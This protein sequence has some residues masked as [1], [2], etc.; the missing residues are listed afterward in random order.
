MDFSTEVPQNIYKFAENAID[1]AGKVG[2]RKR[3]FATQEASNLATSRKAELERTQ[4]GETKRRGLIETGLKDRS[5]RQYG[6]GG[7]EDRRTDLMYGPESQPAREIGL[8][9]GRGGLEEQKIIQTGEL[10]R[11]KLVEIPVPGISG[12]FEG[13]TTPGMADFDTGTMSKFKT[14]DDVVVR[15]LRDP[16]TGDTVELNAAG[17]EIKRTP[18]KSLVTPNSKPEDTVTEVS[19][20]DPLVPKADQSVFNRIMNKIM[21]NNSQMPLEEAKIKA[22]KE[23]TIY[24]SKRNAKQTSQKMTAERL[25]A[26]LPLGQ[27]HEDKDFYTQFFSKGN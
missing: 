25:G 5:V 4:L 26:S 13:Q 21:M 20:K 18:G 27:K 9:Y 24:T 12:F 1:T 10:A 11:R 22:M 17:E 19:G 7:S 16:K 23:Y 8:R 2:E 14:T 15:I 3:Q 6:I